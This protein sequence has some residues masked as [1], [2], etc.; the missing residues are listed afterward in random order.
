MNFVR[1][2]K[3]TRNVLLPAYGNPEGSS[4]LYC[5]TQLNIEQ[6]LQWLHIKNERL[7][8]LNGIDTVRMACGSTWL[9]ASEYDLGS[10]YDKSKF[11]ENSE[12]YYIDSS[13]NQE[14]Q[15]LCKEKDEVKHSFADLHPWGVSFTGFLSDGY[16]HYSTSPITWGDIE[17][18][19][20]G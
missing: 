5:V 18:I 9:H 19:T 3:P 1:S 13:S 7:N 4:E 14:F 20:K 15:N 2:T 10:F 11:F 8:L 17:T 16:H 6:C 12:A